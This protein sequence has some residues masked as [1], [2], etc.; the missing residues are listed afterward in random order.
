VTRSE[1]LA[2]ERSADARQLA[3]VA[4]YSG[5]EAVLYALLSHATINRTTIRANGQV[6]GFDDALREYEDALVASGHLAAGRHVTGHHVLRSLTHIRDGVVHRGI[7]PTAANT[8][9]I[10]EATVAFCGEQ[11]ALVFGID[12]RNE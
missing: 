10:V 1:L 11:V 7:E 5:L 12:P 4:A 8:D 6:I 3:V 2:R 9:Q